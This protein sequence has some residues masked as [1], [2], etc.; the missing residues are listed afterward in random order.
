MSKT[1]GVTSNMVE[2]LSGA[3]CAIMFLKQLTR[4]E[5]FYCTGD[6]SYWEK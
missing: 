1:A 2:G 4:V 5:R 6:A 3:L